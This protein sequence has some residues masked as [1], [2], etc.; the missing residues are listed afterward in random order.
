MLDKLDLSKTTDEAKYE[1]TLESLKERLGVLQ[2]TLRD[3]KI[4]TVIV[5]EGW[6]AAGITMVVHEI[7]HALDPR[8]YTLHAIEKPTGE[9][10]S[11]TFLWRFWLRTPPRGRI[12]LFARSWYSRAISEEMQKHTW[13]KSLK[14]RA[15]QI[16][17]FE[18]K[19][20][21]DGTIILKFFLHISKE[22]QKQRLEER[23]RN[24]LTAW[25]VTPSIWNIHRHYED[26][27]VL[28]DDF[29]QKT[30]TEIAPWIPIEA[31][32]RKYA[33]LKVYSS[34][35][36][37]LEKKS[38]A[39]KE[40]KARKVKA[41]EVVKPKKVTVKRHSHPEKVFTK[42][43]LQET[44][45]NLQIEMLELH[46]LLFKRKIPLMIVY[47][48]WDAAGKG[49]NITRVTRFMNPL[50]YYVVPIAAPTPH[51]KEYHYLRRFIK[52]FPTGG[53][54]A[55]FDRS[56]YGRVLV[57][58]VEKFCTEPEWQRAY[59]EINEME[60][61]FVYSSGGG[62]IKFW[63]EIS[64]EEQLKRFQ[65]R[66]SDPMKIYKITEEDWRNR[67][68][69][70]TYDEAIDEMLARTSTDVAP[71][72]VVESDDKWFARVKALRTVI[73]TAQKLL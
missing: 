1:A 27:L 63:L 53:D 65:Q 70:D 50:G 57:E 45:A 51:E 19:L 18:K 68:K 58:R 52:H 29:I 24:P 38:E 62:I 43:E 36:K 54:I 72:T 33:I 5:I 37:A 35:V 15:V 31:T 40:N 39:A 17:N 41:K 14:S 49:G 55:I 30:D 66:A 61:D 59:G 9:E 12:A 67:E 42:D 3:Q 16:N 4:P 34:I 13:E 8:G 48:G 46:Y 2:R 26:S 60:E 10:K 22:E 56:W 73:A 21:D 20:T 28:I 64:K 44:L 11:H 47:E 6:N 23:E 25:L 69:W 32:D 7:V 71:W